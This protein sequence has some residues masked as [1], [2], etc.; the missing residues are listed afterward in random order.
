MFAE[1]FSLDFDDKYVWDY[2]DETGKEIIRMDVNKMPTPNLPT[3]YSLR[4]SIR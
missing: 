4:E 1:G 3:V 2:E